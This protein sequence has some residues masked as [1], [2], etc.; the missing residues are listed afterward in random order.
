ML[1]VQSSKLWDVTLQN[2]RWK[3]K[4]WNIVQCEVIALPHTVTV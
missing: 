3:T 4:H 1:P 2:R